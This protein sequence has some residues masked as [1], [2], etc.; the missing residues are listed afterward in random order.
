METASY[1]WSP[2]PRKDYVVYDDQG[3]GYGYGVRSIFESRPGLWNIFWLNSI[4][5]DYLL[6]WPQS[7][8]ENAPSYSSSLIE[9]IKSADMVCKGLTLEELA[10]ITFPQMWVEQIIQHDLHPPIRIMW[11][12]DPEDPWIDV[13]ADRIVKSRY[14]TQVE[15]NIIK[16]NFG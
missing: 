14:Y 2:R 6:D 16:A 8:A 3:T 7:D 9:T 11:D 4:R 1:V 15:G 10:E 5:V 12:T 13:M